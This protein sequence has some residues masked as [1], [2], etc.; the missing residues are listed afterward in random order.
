VNRTAMDTCL[1]W[2]RLRAYV[3]PQARSGP[4][5][6]RDASGRAP[7]N[8][9][10]SRTSAA[11]MVLEHS[12]PGYPCILAVGCI[13]QRMS[14]SDVRSVQCSVRFAWNELL[15]DHRPSRAAHLTEIPG[16]SSQTTFL[17]NS[18]AQLTGQANLRGHA[19]RLCNSTLVLPATHSTVGMTHR[20]TQSG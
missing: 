7:G 3:L 17:C 9:P 20:Y 2:W 18:V 15:D 10:V 5:W 4:G 13:L 1:A 12:Y 6:W 16:S 14:S 8:L 19:V 11:L